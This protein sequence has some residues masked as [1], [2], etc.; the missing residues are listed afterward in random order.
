MEKTSDIKEC[1]Y[2]TIHCKDGENHDQVL[3]HVRDISSAFAVVIAV[4]WA[5]SVI[6]FALQ[7]LK[8]GKSK[9]LKRRNN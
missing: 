6:I 4:L 5:H 9:E 2:D 3:K 7:D 8:L 1:I